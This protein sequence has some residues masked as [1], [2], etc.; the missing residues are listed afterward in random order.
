MSE[1]LFAR[2]TLLSGAA[3][4]LDLMG[5]FDFHDFSPRDKEAD[6]R[7]IFADWRAVGDDLYWAMDQLPA[8]EHVEQEAS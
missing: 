8:V 3:R 6:G 2:P 7:A 1:F 5:L 4:A